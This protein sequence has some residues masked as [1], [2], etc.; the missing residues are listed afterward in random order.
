MFKADDLG[1]RGDRLFKSTLKLDYGL[2]YT[3]QQWHE[4]R[5]QGVTAAMRDWIDMAKMV[6]QEFD[7]QNILG[8]QRHPREPSVDDHAGDEDEQL[9]DEDEQLDDEGGNSCRSYWEKQ[10]SRSINFF[11][12]MATAY[13][14]GWII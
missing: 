5:K 1:Q 9:D 13:E 14:R 7:R 8:D 3:W 6:Q 2:F 11:E 12:F 4:A 10:L